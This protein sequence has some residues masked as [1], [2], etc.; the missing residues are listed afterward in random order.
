MVMIAYYRDYIQ[1][2]GEPAVAECVK[3]DMQHLRKLQQYTRC[4]PCV[5]VI[6]MSKHSVLIP[7][8]V[9]YLSVITQPYSRITQYSL[10]TTRHY[11]HRHPRLALSSFLFSKQII[12]SLN[13][14]SEYFLPSYISNIPP[15]T[16]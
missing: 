1:V 9:S 8:P 11:H 4:H 13:S 5:H 3:I 10:D 6:L 7:L 15:K 16:K 2:Y 12:S 14:H